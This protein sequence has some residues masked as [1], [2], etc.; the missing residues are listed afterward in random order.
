M[1]QRDSPFAT[2]GV[3]VEP[4]PTFFE[5]FGLSLIPCS[6]CRNNLSDFAPI[7]A[8][9]DLFVCDPRKIKQNMERR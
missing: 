1:W 3:A 2:F 7:C 4:P 9:F 6:C 8:L 5:L